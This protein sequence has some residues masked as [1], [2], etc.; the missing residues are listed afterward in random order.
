MLTERTE[1]DPIWNL[2]KH[3]ISRDHKSIEHFSSGIQPLDSSLERHN[4]SSL[5]VK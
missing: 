2:N 1:E 3:L 4:V 5:N